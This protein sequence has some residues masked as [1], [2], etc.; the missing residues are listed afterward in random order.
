MNPTR[1]FRGG[2]P[3]A[4]ALLLACALLA[5]APREARAAGGAAVRLNTVGYLPR[6]GKR[7]TLPAPCVE[8]K[9]VRVSDGAAVLRGRPGGPFREADTGED[10]CVADFSALGAPGL[11]RLEA[12]AAR[13]APFRVG[14]EVYASAFRAAVRALH[15]WRCGAAV[16]LEHEGTT[17]AHAACHLEDARLDFVG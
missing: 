8:F 12:G 15:L 11:Y 5:A 13:S 4:H 17:Y 1:R 9:V 2:A 7:A 10:L 3:L 6:H 16:R 14:R